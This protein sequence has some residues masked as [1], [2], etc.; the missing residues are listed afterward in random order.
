MPTLQECLAQGMVLD[1][2]TGQ[3]VPP[4]PPPGYIPPG[5]QPPPGELPPGGVEDPECTWWQAAT[6]ECVPAPGTFPGGGQLPP[7]TAPPQLPGVVT[8]QQCA[9]REALAFDAGKSEESRNVVK[10]AAVSAAVSAAVGFG[11]GYLLLR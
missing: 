1:M 7:G 5:G 8:E 4:W 3:C 10:T 11:L 6:G 2:A 9:A